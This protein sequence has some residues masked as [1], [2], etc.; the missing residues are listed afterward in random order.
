MFDDFSRKFTSLRNLIS[1]C[2]ES[3]ESMKNYVIQIIEIGQKFSVPSLRMNY[4]WIGCLMLDELT[5]K[6]KMISLYANWTL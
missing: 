1:T 4:E 3:C 2:L 6:Y 5:E